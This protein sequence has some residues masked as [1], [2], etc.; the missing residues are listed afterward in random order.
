MTVCL[1]V[2]RLAGI[3]AAGL[4]PEERSLGFTAVRKKMG[5]LS[6]TSGKLALIPAAVVPTR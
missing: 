1:S 6:P 5:A 4:M 3:R 2:D